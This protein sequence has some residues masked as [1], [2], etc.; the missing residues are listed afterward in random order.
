MRRR[1]LSVGVFHPS[2]AKVVR[3]SYSTQYLE[4]NTG[5]NDNDNNSNDDN[6]NDDDDNDDNDDDDDTMISRAAVSA[7]YR[8]TLQLPQPAPLPRLRHGGR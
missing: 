1:S 7:P 6:S 2:P 8:S 5:N 4:N 3:I